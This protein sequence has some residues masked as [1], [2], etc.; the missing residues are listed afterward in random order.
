M[1]ALKEL[2]DNELAELAKELANETGK[3]VTTDQ[4]KVLLQSGFFTPVGQ[5]MEE[6]EGDQDIDMD[7][8]GLAAVSGLASMLPRSEEAL[9]AVSVGKEEGGKKKKSAWDPGNLGKHLPP[10]ERRQLEMLMKEEAES[11]DIALSMD[12][13]DEDGG[14]EAVS[15]E[16]IQRNN[17]RG[18]IKFA[19][20]VEDDDDAGDVDLWR[21]DSPQEKKGQRW[22]LSDKNNEQEESFDS[23]DEE[24]HSLEHSP[25]MDEE[26]MMEQRSAAREQRRWLQRHRVIPFSPTAKGSIVLPQFLRDKIHHVSK[27]L[28]RLDPRVTAGAPLRD[29][30]EGEKSPDQSSS[31]STGVPLPKRAMQRQLLRQALHERM[32]SAPQEAEAIV[33]GT[34]QVERPQLVYS[35]AEAGAY[36]TDHMPGS[37]AILTRVFAEVE[38]LLPDFTPQSMLDFGAGPCT[39]LFAADNLWGDGVVREVLAVEPS[40]SM[41]EVAQAMT[42]W[43][44][45]V[46]YRRYL[47]RG[48]ESA[49]YDM[50]VAAGSLNCLEDPRER[51][52]IIRSL[53]KNVADGGLLVVTETGSPLGFELVKE[54]RSVVLVDDLVP[55]KMVAPCPHAHACPMTGTGN[56][57]HFKQRVQLL[58]EQGKAGVLQNHQDIPYSFAV[59]Q[60]QASVGCSFD[61]P[62][63]PGTEGPW[64]RLVRKP[65]KKGG[66]VILEICSPSGSLDELTVSKSRGKDWYTSA[67]KAR[68]GDGFEMPESLLKKAVKPRSFDAALRKETA[69]RAIEKRT[70]EEKF[71][72]LF[73]EKDKALK[74]AAKKKQKPHWSDH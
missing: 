48:R 45:R 31:S 7:E 39:A 60:K 53:W 65:R 64:G 3:P 19:E 23:D 52:S 62:S 26:D 32:R 10:S 6:E 25:G 18:G 21:D 43:D 41:T 46:N 50:V 56:W 58:R 5:G 33:Q 44:P 17:Q 57:C 63:P 40:S 74:K 42:K 66:H 12:D 34:K 24:Q 68:W 15:G 36:L 13:D 38:E 29:A 11:E 61:Q 9:E 70:P 67:R 4:L 2:S 35:L 14:K 22:N 27:S 55:G 30:V 73:V 54:A 51:R 16:K 49:A 72:R 47:S 69:G 1:D 37:F 59:F 20:D 28:R 8:E 71:Q